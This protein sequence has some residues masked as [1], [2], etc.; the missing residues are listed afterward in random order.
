MKA[1]V[2]PPAIARVLQRSFDERQAADYGDLPE[3]APA[4]VLDLRDGVHGCLSFCDRWLSEQ[5]PS[6]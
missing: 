1:G 6:N 5:Y 2:V 3:T 4:H